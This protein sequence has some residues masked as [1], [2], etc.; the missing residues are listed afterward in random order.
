MKTRLAA[1]ALTLIFHPVLAQETAG[2]PAV[3]RFKVTDDVLQ[4]SP[5][6][7]STNVQFGGFAPWSPHQ[8]LNAWNL[9]YN[10]EPMVFQSQGQVDGGGEDFAQQK[11]M[12]GFSFWDCGRSGYWDG[13][14][15]YF[16]RIENGKMGLVRKAKVAKSVI[17]ND[18]ATNEKTEEKLYLTEKGPEIRSGDFY[19]L[20]MTRTEVP[21]QFREALI[22]GS[23]NFLLDGWCNF[24]GKV[25]WK[26]DTGTFAPEGGSTASLKMKIAGATPESPHGPW[27]WLIAHNEQESKLRF[28]P[29]KQ[30]KISIWLKQE[31][32][33]DPKVRLQ[34]GTIMTR[35]LE[36]T[37]DWKKF[38]FDIPW[39]NPEKP[40]AT[41]QNEGTR[42][43]V[44]AESDGTLWMDNL[45]IYQTDVEP[46][47]IMPR[48]IEALKDFRPAVLRTWGGLHAPTLE[49]WLSEG[50][51]QLNKG[52]YGKSDQP[53]H[54]SLHQSLELCSAVGADPWLVLNPWF[55]AQ[56]NANLM[57]YLGGPAD[58]GFGALRAKQGHPEPYTKT[59]KK[60][61][62]E[63]NNE[64][65]N[66]IMKYSVPGRPEVYAAIA[67]RQ[68]SE[69]KKSPVFSAEKFEFIANGWDSSMD[70]TGWTRR[71]AIASQEADR[72][73][74]AYYFGGWEK[75]ADGSGTSEEAYQ[76][77]LFAPTLE[78]GRK[79]VDAQLMDP[80]L[81]R[82]FGAAV[83]N[84]P[85]L[86]AVGLQGVKSED[87][88]FTAEQLVG[89]AGDIPGLWGNDTKFAD[90]V[91]NLVAG[92]RDP[93]EYPFW[94]AAYRAMANDPE[95]SKRAVAA[96]EL[97]DASILKDLCEGLIDLNAPGRLTPLAKGKPEVVQKWKDSP[98]VEGLAKEDLAV[99]TDKQ[100]K[101]T[102]NITNSLNAILRDEILA[103]LK[104]GNPAII[105]GIRN[106]ATPEL[107]QSKMLNHLDY[108]LRTTTVESPQRRADQ[109]MIAMKKNPEFAVSVLETME[110]KPEVFEAEA[111]N[112]VGMFSA[113][114]ANVFSGAESFRPDLEAKMLLRNIPP[115]VRNELLDRLDKEFAAM[116]GTLSAEGRLLLPVMTKAM[117]GDPEPARALANN[118]DFI[119]MTE[120][121][122]TESIPLPFLEIA[123][124]DAKIGDR[125]VAQLARIPAKGAKKIAN[126]EGGPGYSLP[127]PD[128]P[129]SEEDEN[130]GKSLALG[131]A[132]LD[133]SM[134]FL[135]A[136]SSPITY[137]DY[138]TG[139]YWASHNNPLQMIAYPSWL[140]LKMRN[141]YCPG[142]LISVQRLEGK[143]V[144]VRDKEV[145]RTSNDGKGSKDKV[146]GR[147]NVPLL[148]CYAFRDGAKF[149]V[150]LINRSMAETR[151]AQLDLPKEASGKSLLATLTHSDPK[152]NNRKDENVKIQESAGPE[153]KSGMQVAVP[154]ASVVIV[155]TAK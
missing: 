25:D 65:W 34:V 49:Y 132:T 14:D 118:Q 50:F 127:G 115:D 45:L 26:F 58:K 121:K 131:T 134:Q 52:D 62:L 64:A 28:N 74:M 37:K 128:K 69:L 61:Y 142:D 87:G 23:K 48:D 119:R 63:S 148:A 11:Q 133:V 17:G 59:F 153:I 151:T 68:F 2:A 36:V 7:F 90:S 76:D 71:V 13:A 147:L 70:R 122:I 152:A 146:L 75:T 150:M 32:M 60:I 30:Y 145:L 125:L 129:V 126:Y 95:L 42:L 82:R 66:G 46:F 107:I 83:K 97:A 92:R 15:V 24:V 44:G 5:P 35:E 43:F 104:E 73:D 79:L 57:E 18:P 1:L 111:K 96:L 40:Y 98:K 29:A 77:K 140:A 109:L 86:L 144:D 120:Q 137:Y 4:K 81:F 88:R 108:F 110:K 80:D 100:E 136:G 113:A 149:S 94:H 20:R 114:I 139:D 55:T 89:V 31:G 78:F 112:I 106:E 72:V 101:L 141:V 10:L 51:A 135:A 143:T 99:F 116:S 19:V 85:E 105:T 154:P 103:L 91:K 3:D 38:E 155:R 67:D 22:G 130:M 6:N 102:Y 12:P 21:P 93:I 8:K 39:E 123:K 27:H 47:A 117:R 53:V 84:D 33:S 41:T 16:Y 124:R 9:F 54:A 56:E 138:A